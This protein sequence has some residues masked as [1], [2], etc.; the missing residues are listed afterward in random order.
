M[1]L[2]TGQRLTADLLNSYLVT[3][4]GNSVIVSNSATT[5]GTT[6]TVTLS[7][8]GNLVAGQLYQIQFVGRIASSV[9]TGDLVNFRIREDNLTGAQQGFGVLATASNSTTNGYTTICLAQYT[10][11]S[12][13]SKTFVF[14]L[15]RPATG[16]GN[17]TVISSSSAPSFFTISLMPS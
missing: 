2:V 10:A 4:I 9:L 6:E 17:F 1:A 15:Q 7:V 13:A 5:S 11:A 3:N 8:T 14:T 16:S 12:T